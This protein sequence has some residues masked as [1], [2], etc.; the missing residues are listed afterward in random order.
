[1]PVMITTEAASTMYASALIGDYQ[2]LQVKVDVS[3]LTTSQVDTDGY[4]KP[5]VVLTLN[6]VVPTTASAVAQVETA[7]VSGTI[8]ASGAGNVSVAVT[9]GLLA[10]GSKT[11]AVAV[12]N[13]DTAAQVAGKIRTAMGADAE[14]AALYTVG[15][16]SAT[17][18]LTALTAGT[19]DATLNIATATGT[20][21]GLTAAPTSANTTPGVAGTASEV[22]CVVIEAT[23]IHT[24][25][26]TL[27]SV[28]NDPFVACAV[29]GVLNR[30]VMEDVLGRPLS[31]AEIA[32]LNGPNSKLVLS[33]T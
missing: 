22:P 25:N 4:L 21:S 20:A 27:A 2:P 11:L 12:A 1:M 15:G 32:A 5:N 31:A 23:K 28:T 10:G 24:D 16:S 6:G 9:S 7:T 13:D 26:T 33:L 30:D 14:I 17:V 29:T 19:N 3:A 8:G 18:S